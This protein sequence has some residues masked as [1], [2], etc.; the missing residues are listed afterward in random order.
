MRVCAVC[1]AADNPL[2]ALKFKK[3]MGEI[4]CENH[5]PMAP[6]ESDSSSKPSSAGSPYVG[7]FDFASLV[8]IPCPECRGMSHKPHGMICK[9]C[10]GYGSV[11]VPANNLV[12]YRPRVGETQPSLLTED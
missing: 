11:R 4:Y 1:K 3:H 5:F 12:V 10:A 8:V 7:G 9:G 6:S 2:G